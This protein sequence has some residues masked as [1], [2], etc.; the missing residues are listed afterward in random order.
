M[1]YSDEFPNVCGARPACLGDGDAA[2][3]GRDVVFVVDASDAVGRALFDEHVLES[4]KTMFCASHEGTQSQ[5]SVILYPAPRN[6]KTCGSHE[7][8][9]PLG[10]Y[11]A[12][13]W[14]DKIDELREDDESCCG[15]RHTEPGDSPLGDS[16]GAPARL[17]TGSAPLAEALDAAAA[18]LDARG[19]HAPSNALVVVVAAA[20]PS[21]VVKSESCSEDA[22]AKFSS[23][24]RDWPFAKFESPED[25]DEEDVTACTYLWR[26]V[27]NA[28]RRLRATGA[29]IAGVHLAGLDEGGLASASAGLGAHLVG[30]PWPG[31]CDADGFCSVG[32]QYGGE[33]GRWLY[34]GSRH[35][36]SGHD[37]SGRGDDLAEDSPEHFVYDAGE[38][39]TCEAV[40]RAGATGQR[41]RS[42]VSFPHGAHVRTLHAASLRAASSG[43]D[44]ETSLA[45]AVAPLMCESASS[46]DPAE[47]AISSG[48][49]RASGPGLGKERDGDDGALLDSDTRICATEADAL[50]ID[51]VIS[52]CAGGPDADATVACLDS[53]VFATCA[54]VERAP[55]S[56][57]ASETGQSE[58][59]PTPLASGREPTID[60]GCYD[61]GAVRLVRS[62][63]GTGA[64][65]A[66]VACDRVCR[67]PAAD[68]SVA[69]SIPP[70]VAR[71]GASS[72]R[73]TCARRMEVEVRCEGEGRCEA[74]A[75]RWFAAGREA[76]GRRAELEEEA[77]RTKRTSED[78][79]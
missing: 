28:A 65:I 70:G 23:M 54:A 51:P 20:V 32:A 78:V 35:G 25:D 18:E 56:V 6:A 52:R 62:A 21:P 4:L 40:I 5:A 30:A 74:G 43:N 9:V 34:G 12:R 76:D 15:F 63:D 67:T 64:T 45:R 77:K 71:R 3:R 41:E 11:T 55:S 48:S 79:N 39:K 46:T 14:F 75:V 2:K 31:A 60:S 47:M 50:G 73:E 1:T 59:E 49:R 17:P 58:H 37:G 13:E 66:S 29:R 7:V 27:P 36:G 33:L 57:T 72:F 26:H 61:D 8:A 22:P 19:A 42:V 53:L 68:S 10:R 69:G 38:F 44:A 16:P 24:T